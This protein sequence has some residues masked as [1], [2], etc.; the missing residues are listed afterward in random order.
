MMVS[1][2]F[3]TFWAIM[4]GA[5]FAR[6]SALNK[7]YVQIWLFIIGWAILVA[8]T[9]AE[10]RL[11]IGAGYMFV[12]LQSAL[13]LSLFIAL[14]EFFA[15]PKK[16]SWAQK[17][18]EEQEERDF[19]RGHSHDNISP[20]PLALNQESSPPGTRQSNHSIAGHVNQPSHA[21]DD[22]DA[23][24][25]TERTPLVGGTTPG[26]D[27]PRTTFATNYRRSISAIVTGARRGSDAGSGPNKPFEHEQAWSGRL[28]TW[29]WFLQF[30]LLGPFISM[31]TPP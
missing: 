20:S 5:N 15:L 30:L 24:A 3:S 22:A 7:I 14:C 19:L 12:F 16:A 31:S 8:V 18:R 17:T 1:L 11:R 4:R 6:P 13:F 23:E 21:D 27:H 26:D 29:T 25:P 2:F 9:V 10:D 28:P